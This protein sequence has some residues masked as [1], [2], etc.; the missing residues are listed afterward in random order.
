VAGSCK[1][2]KEPSGSIDGKTF[3]D[4]MDVLLPSQETPR[5]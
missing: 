1:Y 4:Y 2:G 5:S 3:L